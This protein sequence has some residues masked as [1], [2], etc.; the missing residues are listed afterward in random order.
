MNVVPEMQ[1]VV[2]SPRWKKSIRILRDNMEAD[3]AKLI[4][5][6]IPAATIKTFRLNYLR[7]IA[8]NQFKGRRTNERMDWIANAL[9]DKY[10]VNDEPTQELLDA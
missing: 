7:A 1:R 10:F 8:Y 2:D 5:G 4:K 6:G 3:V 9:Y